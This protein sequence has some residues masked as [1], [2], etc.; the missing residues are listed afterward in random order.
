MSCQT[1][2]CTMCD[3]LMY[4]S[5]GQ[6]TSSGAAP[7]HPP[8]TPKPN[9]SREKRPASR[10]CEGKC[11]FTLFYC[12]TKFVDVRDLDHIL[13]IGKWLMM[14]DISQNAQLVTRGAC[15]GTNHEILL[16]PSLQQLCWF[17]NRGHFCH[18]CCLLRLFMEKK[19]KLVKIKTVLPDGDKKLK[20]NL[21]DS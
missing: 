2:S 1:T 18:Y 8:T 3:R 6:I 19:S 10:F 20:L 4:S 13:K 5:S 7:P 11:P 14:M 9:P 15:L 16:K 17:Q 21:A 12:F